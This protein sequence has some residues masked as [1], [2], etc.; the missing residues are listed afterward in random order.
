MFF[1]ARNCFCEDG[2]TPNCFPFKSKFS[3]TSF[4]DLLQRCARLLW[5]SKVQVTRRTH[6][7]ELCFPAQ[8]VPKE[9]IE[10]SCAESFAPLGEYFEI[11]LSLKVFLLRDL[12]LRPSI[13]TLLKRPCIDISKVK[14][15][16]LPCKVKANNTIKRCIGQ[17]FLPSEKQISNQAFSQQ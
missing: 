1:F 11:A 14:N 10:A 6:A 17:D 13:K 2:T 15:M 9:F 4:L 7:A 8:H 5:T 3:Y 16:F 12:F